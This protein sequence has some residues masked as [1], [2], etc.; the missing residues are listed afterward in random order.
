VI[1]DLSRKMKMKMKCIF[2]TCDLLLVI[3][4]AKPVLSTWHVA[5]IKWI[6]FAN[7]DKTS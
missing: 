1:L 5:G 2:F 3:V 6:K 7:N 4:M